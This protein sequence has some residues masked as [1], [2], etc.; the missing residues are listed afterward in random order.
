LYSSPALGKLLVI[1]KEWPKEKGKK[2]QTTIYKTLHR[3]PKS[4]QHEPQ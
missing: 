3:K 1:T 4:E 2:R